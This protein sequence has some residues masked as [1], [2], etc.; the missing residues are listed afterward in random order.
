MNN[1]WKSISYG[2]TIFSWI[3]KSAGILLLLLVVVIAIGEGPPNPFKLTARELF[4]M[5]SLLVT[6]AGI[7]LALWR[8]LFGGIA[9]LIGMIPFAGELHQWIFYA[10]V[11][12]GILNIVCWWLQNISHTRKV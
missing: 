9:I 7:I 11:L 5:I 4:L 1:I 10:F 2:R 8:Q 3:V 6:L 12:V